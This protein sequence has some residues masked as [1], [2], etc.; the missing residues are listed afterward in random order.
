MP[1]KAKSST[2]PIPEFLKKKIDNT[3]KEDMKKAYAMYLI[4]LDATPN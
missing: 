3:I 4:E 1:P 2:G